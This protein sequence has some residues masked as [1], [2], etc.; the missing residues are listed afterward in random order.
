VRDVTKRILT[1]H[2]DSL[3]PCQVQLAVTRGGGGRWRAVVDRV[4]GGGC[5]G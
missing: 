4:G 1:R 5:C 2:R 3:I